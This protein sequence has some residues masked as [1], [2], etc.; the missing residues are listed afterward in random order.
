MKKK[1]FFFFSF[2]KQISQ[3]NVLFEG[4]S[5]SNRRKWTSR[6]WN[7]KKIFKDNSI[8]LIEPHH[9]TRGLNI[10]ANNQDNS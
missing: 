9:V 3:R 10:N 4:L 7:I 6:D 2:K 1:F 8:S 5:T